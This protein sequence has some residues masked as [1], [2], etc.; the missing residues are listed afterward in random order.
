LPA[1]SAITFDGARVWYLYATEFALQG[2]GLGEGAVGNVD[3]GTYL[4]L[5]GAPDT[6]ITLT[7]TP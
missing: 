2:W 6:S 4:L 3:A 7:V 5:H 1:A